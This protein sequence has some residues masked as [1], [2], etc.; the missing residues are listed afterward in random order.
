AFGYFWRWS[1]IRAVADIEPKP[2]LPAPLGHL[3]QVLGQVRAAPPFALEQALYQDP[4][5]G[6]RP[7]ERIERPPLA[8]PS[9]GVA[10]GRAASLHG[11]FD[12]LFDRLA[13]AA[14]AAH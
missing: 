12:E 6:Q 8:L 9:T 1:G 11:L 7:A 4:Q 2:G 5:P 14:G 13:Q 3:Q 10:E